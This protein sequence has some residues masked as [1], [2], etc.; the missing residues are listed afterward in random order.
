ME[1]IGD[2]VASQY[3]RI[4]DNWHAVAQFAWTTNAADARHGQSQLSVFRLNF[5]APWTKLHKR[6]P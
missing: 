6:G 5:G 3:A 2:D 4:P 1:A